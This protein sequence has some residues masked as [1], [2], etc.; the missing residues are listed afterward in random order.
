MLGGI[1]QGAPFVLVAA[2]L[3]RREIGSG[4][5][6]AVAAARLAPYLLC[7]PVAGALAARCETRTVFTAIGLLRSALIGALSVALGAGAPVLVLVSVLFVLVAVGTPTFPALMRAVHDT[8]HARLDRTS[9]LAAGLE[10]AAFGAGPALGGL[11]LLLLDTSDALLVCATMTVVSAGIAW[12]LPVTGET[13]RPIDGRS[14]R[15]VRN[16]SRCLLG[17]EIRTAIVAVLGV[18]ALAGLNAALLVRIPAGLGLGGERAFGLLSLVS[19][20][21][22]F[23][24]FVALLGPIPRGRRPLVPL[25]AAGAAVGLLAATTELS[26]ALVACCVLGTAILTS[27]VLVTGALGRALPRSL[28]APGFGVLDALVTAAMITGAVVAPVLTSSFGLR[29]TLA[30]AA[31][32]AIA[33][34][35]LATCVLPRPDRGRP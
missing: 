6:A 28:V 26:V 32:A 18:N 3:E 4:W 7:S 31:I 23:A 16:A 9:A 13:T 35:L 22:A 20:V 2:E 17:P 15:L 19:G 8:P 25:I 10:S 33:T 24:A 12:F 29:P 21:G 11:L 14:S 5:L 34:P 1:A 27:E 30:I